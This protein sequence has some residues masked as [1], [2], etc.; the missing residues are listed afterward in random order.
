M[1]NKTKLQTST[2]VKRLLFVT[3]CAI[4]FLCG[5]IYLFGYGAISSAPFFGEN[6]SENEKLI[7]ALCYLGTL[8]CLALIPAA[9]LLSKKLF[10]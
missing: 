9:Y 10:K 4:V 5:A 6:P 1:K 7:A 8:I 3:I 2:I